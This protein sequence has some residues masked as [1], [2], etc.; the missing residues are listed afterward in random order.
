MSR[1]QDFI[2]ATIK[3]NK[4]IYEI[5]NCDLHD[6]YFTKTTIGAGG[7]VSLGID[8]KAE[9]IFIKYLKDFGE[10]LSEECGVYGKGEN[11]IIID[12]IDGS[13]N[14]LSKLPYFGS[15]VAYE[16]NDEV[17][18]G[19]VVNF[20]NGDI[21]VRDEVS[22]RVAKLNNL[23]FK[24]VIKNSFSSIGL[25]ERAYQSQTI[26][27]RLKQYKIK[28]RTPGA[29]ALS[30][31]YASYVDFVL[32]EGVMRDYDIKAALFL[33]SDLYFYQDQNLTLLSKDSVKFEK[34]KRI[35]LG[36]DL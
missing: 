22:F 5:I 16:V 33:S 12:P 1:Y 29:V 14:F 3:A 31:A 36:R 28:Y 8:L 20:A 15:S 11:K 18:V 6:S 30:L 32:Y 26:S 23:N 21:F 19:V 34:I 10:I 7:D 4:K 9:E 2:D 25:F 35:V 13:D 27:K 17:V 24:P